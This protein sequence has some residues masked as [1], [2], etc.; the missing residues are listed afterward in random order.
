M[1]STT[2]FSKKSLP[3][4]KNS[5]KSH[6][7]KTTINANFQTVIEE[8]NR[9]LYTI[10]F[11]DEEIENNQLFQVEVGIPQEYTINQSIIL[12][13]G[14]LNKALKPYNCKLNPTS[15]YELFQSKKNGQPKL[16]LP[17]T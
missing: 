12:I 15:K 17:S 1:T 8:D 10:S 2:N 7:H 3:D 6:L 16:D 4:V 14:V 9:K 5:Y 13:V 11:A